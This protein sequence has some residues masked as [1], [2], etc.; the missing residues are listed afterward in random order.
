MLFRCV[1]HVVI[2]EIIKWNVYS[3]VITSYSI[4]YH[5]AEATA[6]EMG[7]VDGR[8]CGPH[9]SPYKLKIKIQGFKAS[10]VCSNLKKKSIK[11]ANGI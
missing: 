1:L 5:I 7:G 11:H 8:R 3:L 9:D 4:P 10:H 6:K 2:K